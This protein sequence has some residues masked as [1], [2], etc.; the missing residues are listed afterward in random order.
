MRKVDNFRK[1]VIFMRAIFAALILAVA[2]LSV[3]CQD[4]GMETV[5]LRVISRAAD[6][7]SEK[8]GY[9]TEN[10]GETIAFETVPEAPESDPVTKSPETTPTVTPP[11]TSGAESENSA[12]ETSVPDK[13][14]TSAPKPPEEETTAP[15]TT[16][17]E[18]ASVP[19]RTIPDKSAPV[20]AAPETTAQPAGDPDS[21]GT[22]FWVDSGEVWHIKESCPSLSRSKNIRSGSV[23]K[24]MKAGK[25]RVCK[26]CGK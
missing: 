18:T 4:S 7:L 11:V 22:V 14:V 25:S 17:P 21:T 12:P 9:D 3:S 5:D 16:K 10:P 24:A 26:R 2:V 13:P 23:D 8:S 19:D 20:T 15:E 6:T 1:E